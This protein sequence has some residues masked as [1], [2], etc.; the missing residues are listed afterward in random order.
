MK[1]GR[2]SAAGDSR[3]CPHCKATI[4]KS[5]VSC[6]LCRH[7]LRFGSA[8]AEEV[9]N[10]SE[11]LLSVDGTINHPG[12]GEALEYFILMEVRDETGKLVSRQSLGVGAIDKAQKRIFSLRVEMSSAA[13]ANGG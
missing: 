2:V 10:P 11:C 1:N 9:C 7:V 6:P 8:A 13:L 3:S 4:L 12:A 5:S